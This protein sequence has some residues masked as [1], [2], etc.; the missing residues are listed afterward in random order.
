MA[1]ENSSSSGY[2][3]RVGITLVEVLVVLALVGIIGGIAFAGVRGLG[4]EQ[5]VVNAQKEFL[6]A[7]RAAQSRA[8]TGADGTNVTRIYIESA[9]RYQV[10]GNSSPRTIDLTSQYPGV[11]MSVTGG[12]GVYICFSHNS[13]QSF[14]A[15][16]CGGCLGG[17]FYACRGTTQIATPINVTFSR[18]GG[19]GTRTVVVSGNGIEIS[20][21]YEQ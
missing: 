3:R 10:L 8:R 12:T 6:S 15:N 5:S 18:T 16:Q 4:N 13:R 21:I 9:T 2:L 14:L 7:A 20:R 11:T 1:R 17:Q 19:G